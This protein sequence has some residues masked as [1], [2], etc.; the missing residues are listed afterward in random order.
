MG[1]LYDPATCSCD[2]D[3]K[4]LVLRGITPELAKQLPKV[5][6]VEVKVPNVLS[7]NT[8]PG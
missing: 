8:P 1:V 7:A 2:V 4:G 5:L 6:K 3:P